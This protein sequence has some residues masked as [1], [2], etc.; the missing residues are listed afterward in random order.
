MLGALGH[1]SPAVALVGRSSQADLRMV[2]AALP[3]AL[4]S[5]KSKATNSNTKM[6][7]LTFGVGWGLGRDGLFFEGTLRLKMS[8]LAQEN[9]DAAMLKWGPYLGPI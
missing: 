9:R 3:H 7:S 6:S 4:S 8:E 5:R 1:R 2:A